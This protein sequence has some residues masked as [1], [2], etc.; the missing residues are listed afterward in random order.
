MKRKPP[1][2]PKSVR[3]RH[4]K[5]NEKQTDRILE[6]ISTLREMQNE[7]EVRKRAFTFFLESAEGK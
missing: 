7:G 6:E 5:I 3:S 1:S 2:K 4:Q